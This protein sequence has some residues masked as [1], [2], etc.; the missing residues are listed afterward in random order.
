MKASEKWQ[1]L[2][3]DRSLNKVQT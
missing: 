3:L 2:L 1:L